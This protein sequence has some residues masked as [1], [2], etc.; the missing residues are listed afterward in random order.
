MFIDCLDPD[1]AEEVA[2]KKTKSMQEEQAKQADQPGKIAQ[3]LVAVNELVC[4]KISTQLQSKKSRSPE[5][6]LNMPLNQ[7]FTEL[8]S[9]FKVRRYSLR[10]D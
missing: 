2:L 9:K 8:L 6:I 7:S 4:E 5:E 10:E 1:E 3:R